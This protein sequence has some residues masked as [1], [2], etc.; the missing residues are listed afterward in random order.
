MELWKPVLGFEGF[1][2][3]ST[4]GRVR[5][6]PRQ[7]TPGKVLKPKVS[8]KGYHTINTSVNQK[9]KTMKISRMVLSAFVGDQ[10]TLE[11]RHLDG[12]KDN[13]TLANLAWGTRSE[14]E[15]D[16][17]LHGTVLIGSRNPKAVLTESDVSEIKSLISQGKSLKEIGPLFPKL[18]W[19]TFYDIRSGKVW[20][21][22]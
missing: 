6:L 2:E 14:N 1:Y 19:R 7:A 13:N 9:R 18:G 15:Q 5:S 21:H 20:K 4:L 10:P 8:F 22:V 12:N 17:V 16:K 11:A 3:V